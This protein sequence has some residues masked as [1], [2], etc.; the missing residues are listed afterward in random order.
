LMSRSIL[1][2]ERSANPSRHVAADSGNWESTTT[3]ASGLTS[4]PI[5]PPRIWNMP[6]PRRIGVNSMDGE[7]ARARSGLGMEASARAA[8]DCLRKRRRCMAMGKNEG[9]KSDTRGTAP[10]FILTEGLTRL[11]AACFWPAE[12]SYLPYLR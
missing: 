12:S 11:D 5:V 3:T 8:D 1:R 9:V 6:V 10:G 4:H 2:S 7:A